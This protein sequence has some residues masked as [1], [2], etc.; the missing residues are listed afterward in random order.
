[1]YVL[2]VSLSETFFFFRSE[3]LCCSSKL[4][5]EI[6]ILDNATLNKSSRKF[7]FC[8]TLT[9]QINGMDTVR[10]PVSV[11]PYEDPSM[12]HQQRLGNVQQ[13]GPDI[14]ES[15]DMDEVSVKTVSEASANSVNP[16]NK[17]SI[18]EGAQSSENTSASSEASKLD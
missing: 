14:S 12:K 18:S 3:S 15:A 7:D 2:I 16:V 17:T 4:C 10:V 11:I 1:M 5:T 6:E 8:C 13:D 9:S